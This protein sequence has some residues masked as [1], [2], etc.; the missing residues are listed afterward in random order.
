MYQSNL[1]SKEQSILL[2]ID[3]QERL[4]AVIPNREQIITNVSK[5]IQ[6]ARLHDVPILY[7]EQYPK[8]LGA[9]ETTLLALLNGQPRIEKLS[10]SACGQPEVVVLLKERQRPQ[11]ILA[12]VEAH[13]CVLQTALDLLHLGYHP[14]IVADAIS[15][16]HSFDWQMALKR[17]R[18]HGA[19][20]TSVES[21]LFEWTRAAGTEVFKKISALVK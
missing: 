21:V 9:T 5:L 19:T 15:S 13:V 1:I 6:G 2:V 8:G 7:T 10:F 20:I 14:Y 12:G 18:Q 16:R 4:M 17:L 11:V 3:V